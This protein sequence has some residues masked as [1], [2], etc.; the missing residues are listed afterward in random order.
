METRS[1]RS[2]H[3]NITEAAWNASG[4]FR[5]GEGT[6]VP[7]ISSMQAGE[8]LTINLW[9]DY[10]G[11]GDEEFSMSRTIDLEASGY[12]LIIYQGSASNPNMIYALNYSS[13]NWAETANK[14]R[15]II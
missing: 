12:H 1:S 4:G 13:R 14:A 15:K 11:G 7:G 8:I 5:T 6:L 9:S 2:E 10:G 3:F